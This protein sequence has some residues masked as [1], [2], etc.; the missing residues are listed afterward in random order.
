[1]SKVNDLILFL[2]KNKEKKVS[3]VINEVREMC[4][5]FGGGG[6]DSVSLYDK[7]NKLVGLKCWYFEKWCCVI[8]GDDRFIVFGLKVK[9]SSGF[10]NMSKRG[11]SL[12]YNG[13]NKFKKGELDLLRS[14]VGSGI[15]EVEIKDKLLKFKSECM[16]KDVDVSLKNSFDSLEDL[17][18][19]LIEKG[20]EF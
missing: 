11:C 15:S 9:N 20:I 17:K 2:D 18:N 14:S 3:S 19:Y 7:N 4:S 10:N 16:S 5:K 13:Y 6:G 12:W 8:E 1:M